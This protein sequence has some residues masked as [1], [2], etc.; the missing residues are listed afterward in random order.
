MNAKTIYNDILLRKYFEALLIDK[1]TPEQLYLDLFG[2]GFDVVKTYLR[3]Y[4]KFAL[5]PRLILKKYIRDIKDK[6]EQELKEHVF[7]YGWA[8]ID[9]RYNLGKLTDPL[10]EADRLF[11]VYVTRAAELML[12]GGRPPASV[13]RNIA[14]MQTMY[15]NKLKVVGSALSEEEWDFAIN[16]AEEAANN[17]ITV[18]KA[19][20]SVKSPKLDDTEGDDDD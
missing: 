7:N 6:Q 13:V 8:S 16:S 14:L 17:S 12:K 19:L 10:A 4:G 20:E 2:V 3:L 18:I 1:E 9:V 5:Q 15:L 11:K